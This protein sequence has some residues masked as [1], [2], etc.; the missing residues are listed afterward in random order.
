MIMS[1][2]QI[3][4]GQVTNHFCPSQVKSQVI[5]VQVK[6]SH[7]NWRLESKS[8]DRPC[9]D[10]SRIMG[11]IGS[12]W[13]SCDTWKQQLQNSKTHRCCDNYEGPQEINKK[14]YRFHNTFWRK[15]LPDCQSL[16]NKGEGE[17]WRAHAILIL[18]IWIPLSIMLPHY[19]LA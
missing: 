18:Q 4:S 17:V 6:S 1:S 3:Y 19:A 7:K 8:L 14:I 11:V 5:F 16:H 15:N 10:N 13:T 2:S 9:K 12:S